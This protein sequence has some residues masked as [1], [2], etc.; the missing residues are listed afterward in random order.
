M[1]KLTP[2]QRRMLCRHMVTQSGHNFILLY[3][4]HDDRIAKKIVAKGYGEFGD[5]WQNAHNAKK[6]ADYT[7]TLYLNTKGIS[8]RLSAL[9]IESDTAGTATTKPNEFERKSAV[10]VRAD[11][12]AGATIT[13]P[14]PRYHPARVWACIVRQYRRVKYKICG[15]TDDLGGIS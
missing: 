12:D 7:N 4:G 14:R 10:L 13:A 11:K 3:D 15:L 5:N 1:P 6:R 8:A 2:A 9:A